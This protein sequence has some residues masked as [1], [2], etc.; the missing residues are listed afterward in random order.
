MST[1]KDL[2]EKRK[3]LQAENLIPSWYTTAGL[4]L[5]EEKYEYDTKGR[6]VRGQF[7]RIA[8][9]AA[10]YLKGTKYEA[11]AENKFFDLLWNGYLSPSTPVL[12]N[13]GTD[14]GMA[15]SCSRSDIMD[16]IYDFYNNLLENAQLSKYGFGTASYLGNIRARGEKISV[17]GKASGIMPVLKMH[18][19]ASRDVSQ[20]SNRR[21]A[22]A[23]Y[24]PID[25]NDFDEVCNYVQHEPDDVN[26]GWNISDAFIR[27]L[28]DGDKEAHRRFKKVLKT[29]MLT[30]RGYFWFVDKVNRARPQAYKNNNLEITGSNLCNE[31]ALFA[32]KDHTVT[33]VLSSMN[34]AR[35]DEWKNTDAVFWSTIFLDCI[36]EDF[37]QRSE[38]IPGLE[39]A[40]RSTVKGR[41]L[42][43]GQCG[44]ASL[45]LKRRIPFES[46]EAHFLNLEVAEFI[47]KEAEKA[48]RD[49]ALEFGEPE[50]CKGLGVR[51]THLIAI[52][53]TKSTAL[54]MGGVSEGINP[55]PAFVYVQQTA[56]GNVE[57]INPELLAL[58]K[59]KDAYT[60]ANIKAIINEYG[61]VQNAK[62]LTDEEKLVFKTAF[63]INQLQI[64]R[65]AASRKKYIDQWQ[66]LNLFFSANEKEAVIAKVHR[67]AFLNESILGLYY[68][69]T[70][71]GVKSAQID[72]CLAC[73]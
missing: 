15:V 7:E 29:K 51:N 21:G 37:I 65:L 8:K 45:F 66:S 70:Q 49:L 40:R 54:L 19:Q 26:I 58:M 60:P 48:S 38:N 24:L 67:E 28:E 20:G 17:G 47:Q 41:A 25:H 27:K 59:E 1:Y 30:G 12:S 36:A 5:F 52:A 34:V 11:E 69:Y 72:E 13:L 16:S 3:R 31:I 53:P 2:S 50:W 6:S 22:W 32:D 18:V 55:D 9:T 73:Q 14:K 35:Y 39:K 57:R 33:C 62:W 63:E 68:I 4:Q 61:S 42:G 10:S 64:L 23:G 43:L 56:A 44:L 46:L 71:A